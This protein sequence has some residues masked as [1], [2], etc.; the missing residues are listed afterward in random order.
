MS[1]VQPVGQGAVFGTGRPLARVRLSTSRMT[2]A[3]VVTG[4]LMLLLLYAAYDHG[5]AGLSAGARV[6]ALAA[7]L[8]AIVASGVL[9]SGS[10]RLTVPR[11]AM[12]ATG[13]LTGFA[14]WNAV[15]LAW[16]IA[17]DATW[18]EFN[19]VLTYVLVLGIAIAIG[20]SHRDAIALAAR[21]F[22]LVAVAVALYGL[23]Q[24]LIP[25][26][27]IGGLVNFNQTGGFARLQEPL[28]YW[29]AL[30]LLL[31]MAVPIALAITVDRTATRGVRLAALLSIELLLLTIVLTY[32][33]GGLLALAFGTAVGLAV[34]GA[35]LR[36]L[37]WA[38]LAV[39]TTL[40]PLVIGLADRSLATSNI[41]LGAREH[42]GAEL[43]AVLIVSL[44][45]LALVA[46]RGFAAERNVHVAPERV[47]G[48][49][50]L[51]VLLAALVLVLGVIAV[52][53]S[54]RGLTGTISHAW[55]GFTAT[56]G[57]SDSS[58]SRLLSVD[59]ENRWVWWKE[60][61]GAF[62]DRPIEGWGGGS[63]AAVHLLYRD[64]TL[65]TTQAHS[66][67]LQLLAETGIVG[68]A[69]AIGAFGLL[70]AVA[71][72]AVRRLPNGR[73]RLLAAALLAGACTYALHST[74]DWDWA[75]PGVTL[76]ALVFLGVL[77]GVAG[78]E[79]TTRSAHAGGHGVALGGVT[80]VLC[81]VAFS[82]LLPSLAASRASA[83]LLSAARGTPAA[84]ASANSD[85]QEATSF[86]PLSDQGLLVQATVASRRGQ[87][88]LA[89]ADVVRAI[90]RDPTDENAW[91]QLAIV[92]GLLG[93]LREELAAAQRMVAVNPFDP[94]ARSLAD[95]A[96]LALTPPADSPT[97]VVTPVQ[98]ASP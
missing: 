42:A 35:R 85:A 92:E 54:G 5:A 98:S 81:V 61:V 13:L 47:R 31:A 34:S 67:P 52:A 44:L 4:L 58:P 64:N 39:L 14:V 82:G 9:W 77:A 25:G 48:I 2:A 33:R 66:V 80:V 69:L 23:G 70:L 87:L 6:Q 93:N 72:A 78:R 17:P 45:V 55:S 90:G 56:E 83:A 40:P 46:M 97:S 94:V 29:N 26:V 41:A 63:F 74:Y 60:A 36:S 49:G 10:L 8:A 51:L 1:S 86:D 32:S 75:I 3:G 59:S 18:T 7:G 24:K 91:E 53:L 71:L 88:A 12:I 62:S 38:G 84:V 11:R 50:R 16:S 19:R 95:R 79:A 57:T 28:G 22:L 43:A 37:M 96:H 89:R 20:A 30:A 73:E 68:A 65:S 21:G 27:R 76:P 15:T